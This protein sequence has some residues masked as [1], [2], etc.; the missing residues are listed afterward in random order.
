[1]TKKEY[2]LWSREDEA[3]LI[4]AYR[5]KPEDVSE[6]AFAAAVKGNRTLD[7]V[8]IKIREMRDNGIVKRTVSESPYPK[9]DAPLVMEGDALILPDLEFPFHHA[10]FVNRCLELAQGWNIRQCILAGDVLHFDSIS[11]W[12]PNWIQENKGGIMEEAETELMESIKLLTPKDQGI[13]MTVLGNIGTRSEQDG[14][15]TELKVAR[16]ELEKLIDLFGRIDFLLGN[17]EGRLLRALET[18][19]SPTDLLRLLTPDEKAV[20]ASWRIAPYYFS[21]LDTDAGRY[22]IEHPKGA[23]EGTAQGLAAKYHAHIIMGHSHL[24]DFSWDVSGMYYAIHAGHCVDELR[25]PYAAQRHTTKRTHKHGA[26]IVRGG[27]PWLLHDG[28]DW[29][30]LMRM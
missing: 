29:T 13:M 20:P 17:H 3:R 12:E 5:N 7:S 18:T 11:G 30:A 21:Y 22:Q 28:V 8:R 14:M 25:L 26:V 16:R 15:S 2:K 19:L 6:R 9:Y 27:C 1:M 10:D 4:E 24:L 23:A